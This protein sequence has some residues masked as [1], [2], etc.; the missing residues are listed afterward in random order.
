MSI[1]VVAELYALRPLHGGAMWNEITQ[2][3]ERIRAEQMAPET[4]LEDD[5]VVT[6]EDVDAERDRRNNRGQRL[7]LKSGKIVDIATATRADFDNINFSADTALTLIAKTIPVLR[8]TMEA[9]LP[10]PTG[11]APSYMEFRDFYR[12]PVQVTYHEMAEIEVRITDNI[13]AVNKA[14]H[15]LKDMDPDIP[16]DYTDDKYWPTIPLPPER[17]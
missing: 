16:A 8:A 2:L 7:T 10:E 4:G 11:P 15:L 17:S 13:V 3:G 5:G 12:E 14:A 6:F 1:D 9:I